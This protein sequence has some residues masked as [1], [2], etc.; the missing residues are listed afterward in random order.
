MGN[1]PP[2]RGSRTTLYYRVKGY[3]NIPHVGVTLAASR[4]CGCPSEHPPV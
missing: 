4:V 3:R 1:I 2:R